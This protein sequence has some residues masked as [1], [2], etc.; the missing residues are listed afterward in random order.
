MAAA[1]PLN[2]SS[3]REQVYR[4][5]RDAINRG[6]LAPGSFLDQNA[7]SEALGISRT[8]LRDALLQLEAEGFVSILPRR[9]VQVR[10][11]TLD[12]ARH[13]YE[14][15]GALEGAALLAVAP[16]FA[17]ADVR[18]MR[19]LNADMV[20]ALGDDDFETYYT[21]NLA[22]HDVFLERSDNVWLARTVRVCKERLYDFARPP[23]FVPDWEL[24]S[25]AEHAEFLDLLERGDW[26]G[27]ADYLRDVHWGFAVQRPFVERY[28]FGGGP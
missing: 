6:E 18:R 9:G 25:T 17:A 14:I 27:A 7:I 11:L 21:L 10:A 5:L 28:Y 12:D 22:F 15:I 26:P 3:L 16:T 1:G 13:L 19:T 8:P 20:V 24:A 4:H 23:N 2:T